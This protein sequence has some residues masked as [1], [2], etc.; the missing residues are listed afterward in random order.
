MNKAVLS[1]VI[2]HLDK[3]IW[4]L[5]CANKLDPGSVPED[6]IENLRSTLSEKRQEL[7]GGKKECEDM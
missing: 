5:E 4:N 7:W 3:A 2:S 1:F 6:V